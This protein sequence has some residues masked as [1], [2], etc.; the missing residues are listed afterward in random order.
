MKR[1]IKRFIFIFI[2]V[3]TAFAVNDRVYA[4]ELTA[5]EEISSQVDEMLEDYSIDY[6]ISDMTELS[7]GDLISA[8]GEALSSRIQ[9]PFRL[10]GIIMV[11]IVFSAFMK[12]S[13]ETA[14]PESS[15]ANIYNLVCTVSAVAVISPP[16]LEAYENAAAAIDRGG[17]F[18]LVFVPVFSGIIMISGGITSAGLYNAVTIA[19]SELVMQLSANFFM[20]LVSASA[21]LAVSGSVFPNVS[22]DGIIRLIKKLVTWGLTVSVTLFTGFVS[23]KCTVGTAVDGF[24]AKTAK[25]MI[26]GFVPVIGGAV[27]DAYSTV[28]GSFGVMKCTA[29]TAGTI[30]VVLILLPPVLEI[31]AF[32][33]V[34]WIGSSAAEMF[35]VQPVE[36]LLKN[37][38]SGLSIAMSILV[39][40]SMM[41]IISTAIMMKGGA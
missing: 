16:L 9:A 28:K 8:V 30:A 29:G 23:L 21:A 25:F 35:S 11:I 38:D 39:C 31:L 18:M 33:A 2:A 27:S 15:L 32:R 17:G 20:P 7:P 10:L 37:L 14:F 1:I 3:F 26:S 4:A 24:A 41:F 6:S 40:F 13:G 19:A 36:K 12:S 22:V 34:M 5:S